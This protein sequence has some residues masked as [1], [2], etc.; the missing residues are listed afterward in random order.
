MKNVEVEEKR[1]KGRLEKNMSNY[2]F[3]VQI[4][5]EADNPEEAERKLSKELKKVEFPCEVEDGP[6]EL[7]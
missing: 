7:T 5:V 6:E 2:G 4:I 1:P 3:I